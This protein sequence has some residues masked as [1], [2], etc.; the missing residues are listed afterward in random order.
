MKLVDWARENGI[1]YLT[2]YRW[3]RKGILP[4]R[5]IQMPTGT[6]LVYPNEPINQ[7][8]IRGSE[9]NNDGGKA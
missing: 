8:N 6:I 5:A 7:N 1:S 4:V 9:T 2:A 3:F